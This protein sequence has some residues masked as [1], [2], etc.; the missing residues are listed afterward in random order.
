MEVYG[1]GFRDRGLGVVGLDCYRDWALGSG[2]RSTN[3]CASAGFGRAQGL[4][5]GGGLHA[6][7][8]WGICQL[9]WVYCA[10]LVEH[11]H[12]MFFLALGV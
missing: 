1:F 6:T 8:A 2:P 11:V 10:M 12:M 3:K 4:G 7:G 9:L 5:S